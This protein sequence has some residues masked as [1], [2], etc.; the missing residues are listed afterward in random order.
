MYFDAVKTK[1]LSFAFTVAFVSLSCQG[2]LV[3]FGQ[4]T[5]SSPSTAGVTPTGPGSPGDGSTE[6]P[7]VDSDAPCTEPELAFRAPVRRLTHLEFNN[8]VRDLLGDTTRPA[9]AFEKQ[10]SLLGFD[11]NV[12]V[13]SVNENQAQKYADTAEAL[14][15]KAT[16]DVGK[17]LGCDV[18]AKGE[19]PCFDQWL[20]AFGPK[21]FRQPFSAEDTARWKGLYTSVRASLSFQVAVQSVLV[22]LLQSPRFLYRVEPHQ[23]DNKTPSAAPLEPHALATRLSYFLWGTMPDD[24]LRTAANANQL[25]T[26]DAV[27]AQVERMLRDPK[28]EFARKHFYAQWLEVDALDNTQKSAEVFPEF[29]PEVRAAMKQQFERFIDNVYSKENG[30]LVALLTGAKV[31]ANQTLAAWYPKASV[32]AGWS[33]VNRDPLLHAGFLTLPGIMASHANPDATSPTKR[34][35]FILERLLCSV[36]PEPPPDANVT[37]PKVMPNTTARERY[38]QHTSNKSCAACHRLFDP[39]GL[40]LEGFDGIGRERTTEGTAQ[41]D[42]SGE[43]VATD[44]DGPYVGAAESGKKLATSKM[45]DGCV[46]TNW[47]RYAQGRIESKGESCQLQALR[48]QLTKSKDMREVVGGIAASNAFRSGG[49]Q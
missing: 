8:T 16:A 30:S 20:S 25:A 1:T 13:L 21:A 10:G 34:G 36:A 27:A 37:P 9:D 24:A 4:S 38:A 23:L 3:P 7:S 33:D 42:L 6:P 45:V 35:K 2:S 12:G 26:P 14:A 47:F 44:I 29:T 19:G 39:L 49:A 11:N 31:Q 18:A 22:G 43:F 15:T 40:A 28:A 48:Q 32:T 17:F 5:G 46:V 41:I